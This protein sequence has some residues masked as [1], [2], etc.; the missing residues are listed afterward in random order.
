MDVGK[1]D[2]INCN[3]IEL[4]RRVMEE[5]ALERGTLLDADVLFVSQRL[6]EE[7]LIAQLHYRKAPLLLKKAL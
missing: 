1:M 5:L 3:K 7:I 4:L 2:E 6:D